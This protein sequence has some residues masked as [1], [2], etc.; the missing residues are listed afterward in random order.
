MAFLELVIF[1]LVFE[2]RLDARRVAELALIGVSQS[3]H[4]ISQTCFFLLAC[5]QRCADSN[6]E[7]A[8]FRDDDFVRF[9][10]QR[11]D[12]SFPELRQEAERSA[13]EGDLPPDRM[14]AGQS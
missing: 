5:Q 8:V 4:D 2:Q 13:E 12:K 11:L 6:E 9:Q 10:L 14:P 3:V 7:L 1:L